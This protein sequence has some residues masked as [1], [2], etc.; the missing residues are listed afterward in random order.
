MLPLEWT[1]AIV[2]LLCRSLCTNNSIVCF[3]S[4]PLLPS[5]YRVLHTPNWPWTHSLYRSRMTL[6]F[7][8]CWDRVSLCSRSGA[9]CVDQL[10]SNS[11]RFSCFCILYAG[12][13]SLKHQAQLL[14]FNLWSS[15]LHSWI[16]W[17]QTCVITHHFIQ[18]WE[19]MHV[20]VCKHSTNWVQ[21]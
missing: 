15:H 20:K 2:D 8:C 3:F 5:V 19:S 17:L 14:T 18:F 11:L 21:E 7:C 12:I 4:F 13:I 6:D 9:C 10:A 1:R 16:L